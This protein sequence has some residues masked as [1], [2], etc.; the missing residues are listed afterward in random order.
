M[1][2]FSARAILV[3]VASL[4]EQGVSVLSDRNARLSPYQPFVSFKSNMFGKQAKRSAP[5]KA[6]QVASSCNKLGNNPKEPPH[7]QIGEIKSRDFSS[8]PSLSGENRCSSRTIAV[9]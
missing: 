3:C 9:T 1:S 6:T 5:R 4:G 8:R 7:C 2:S